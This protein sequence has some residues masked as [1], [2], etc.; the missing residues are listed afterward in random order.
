[1]RD[2]H[3]ED[4]H[5][6]E[7]EVKAREENLRLETNHLAEKGEVVGEN[8]PLETNR[9]VEAEEELGGTL[10]VETNRL[11]AQDQVP[12]PKFNRKCRADRRRGLPGILAVDRL[13]VAGA[14]AWAVLAWV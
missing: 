12:R 5:H 1:M 2:R 10:P 3:R 4:R 9:P 6:R 7:E 11:V 14:A 8:L 13:S